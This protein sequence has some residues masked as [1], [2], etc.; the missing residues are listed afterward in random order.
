MVTLPTSNQKSRVTKRLKLDSLRQYT[1]LDYIIL[2]T[3]D[4]LDPGQAMVVQDEHNPGWIPELLDEQR[5][6]TPDDIKFD[7]HHQ[8][9]TYEL[10]VERSVQSNRAAT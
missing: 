2:T 4:E 10:Y 1:N 5:L 8:D 3:H 9:G 7:A 6:E